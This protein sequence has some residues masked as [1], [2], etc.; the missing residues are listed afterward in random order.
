MALRSTSASDDWILFL[1]ITR[2][3]LSLPGGLSKTTRKVP[4]LGEDLVP[5][6]ETD[7]IARNPRT[8]LIFEIGNFI[9]ADGSDD[10]K[11][12]KMRITAG[13]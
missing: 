13:L 8:R 11:C 10:K 4:V 7:K 6:T 3:F 9:V 5:V 1:S 12:V 2:V